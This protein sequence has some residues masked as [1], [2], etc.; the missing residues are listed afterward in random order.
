MY[1]K[2]FSAISNDS[3]NINILANYKSH[4][5][6]SLFLC[7]LVSFIRRNKYPQGC[8]CPLYLYSHKG[9]NIFH[10][11]IYRI[12]TSLSVHCKTYCLAFQKRRF[13]RVKAAVL[14]CK[15]YAFATPN[16]NYHFSYELSLQNYSFNVG[17]A[18]HCVPHIRAAFLQ[19]QERAESRS[20]VLIRI[21]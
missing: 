6:E 2:L 16:Q 17:G 5:E 13:C 10:K 8:N 12:T 20:Y 3:G 19:C 7:L 4:Y 14:R 21:V 15:T 18:T 11:H 9:V 1:G